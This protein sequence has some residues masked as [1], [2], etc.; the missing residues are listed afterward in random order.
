HFGTIGA[1]AE[2]FKGK[3]RRKTEKYEIKE[4]TLR[5]CV[6]ARLIKPR[7]NPALR[8]LANKTREEKLSLL[9]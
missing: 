2:V 3:T 9:R 5:L 4:K 7:K 8:S 1:R 6:F